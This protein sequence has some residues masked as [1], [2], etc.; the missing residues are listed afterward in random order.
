MNY[1][2]LG[3]IL[4][5]IMVLEGVLMLAPLLVSLIYKESWVTYSPFCFLASFW[6]G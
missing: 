6:R 3:K 1:K 4:G 2:K 5:K